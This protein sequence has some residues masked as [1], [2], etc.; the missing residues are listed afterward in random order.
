MNEQ[1]EIL[2][3]QHEC[4]RPDTRQPLILVFEA[5]A[6][7]DGPNRELL[8]PLAQ[9]ETPHTGILGGTAPADNEPSTPP[10]GTD[11]RVDDASD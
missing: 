10:G 5:P 1:E 7:P 8:L 6:E 3:C 4:W 9:A 11:V 2:T